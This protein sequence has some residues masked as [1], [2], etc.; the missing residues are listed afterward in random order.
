MSKL[1][2]PHGV[3]IDLSDCHFTGSGGM[4]FL[5][6]MARHGDLLRELSHLPSLKR[7]WLG[8]PDTSG[9]RR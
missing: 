2:N 4:C 8:V 3:V 1:A 9:H 7:P 5:S 6:G